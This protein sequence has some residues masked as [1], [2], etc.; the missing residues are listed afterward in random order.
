MT[1][2]ND[3]KVAIIGCGFVGSASAFTLLESGMF[4]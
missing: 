4:S 3:R 1:K 2:V